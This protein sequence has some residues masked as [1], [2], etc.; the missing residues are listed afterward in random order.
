MAKEPEGQ[1]EHPGSKPGAGGKAGPEPIG[2]EIPVRGG[3]APRWLR[4]VF[5]LLHLW[6]AAYLVAF[7]RTEPRAI[8]LVF[9]GLVLAWLLFFS[10][11]RRPPEL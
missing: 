5:I 6:A 9:A 4:W 2:G 8:L 10:A 1:S 11:T 3:G 7:F